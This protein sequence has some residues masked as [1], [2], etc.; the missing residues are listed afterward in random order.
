L[1][2]GRFSPKIDRVFVG[3]DEY[4]AAHRYMQKEAWIGKVVIS[5]GGLKSNVNSGGAGRFLPAFAP[6]GMAPGRSSRA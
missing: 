6:A 5:L 1:A 4:A 2:A 3:L